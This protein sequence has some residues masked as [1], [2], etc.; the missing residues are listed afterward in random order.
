MRRSLVRYAALAILVLA[1][2]ACGGKKS[3]SS[4]PPAAASSSSAAP[5]T[6]VA[7]AASDTVAKGGEHVV[8]SATVSLLGDKLAL[9]GSGD[10]KS[11]PA[12][13][14]MSL[15]IK[16]SGINAT[17]DEV[18]SGNTAY[19]RTPLL[20]SQLPKGKSWISVNLLKT[21]TAFGVNLNSFTDATP[22]TTLDLLSKATKATKVG[23]NH[24]RATVDLSKIAGKNATAIP[25]DVW[26]NSDGLIEKVS[27]SYTGT[28]IQTVF[29]NYGE[30]VSVK[31][32]SASET[33][34]ISK[35]G[36]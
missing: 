17:V 25:I 18:V 30:K 29:S 24:Y 16:S 15:K 4:T 28:K 11:N 2:A 34:D 3:P 12:L 14:Q 32:P 10:F 23:D 8:V 35:L 5:A 13:G 22:T 7:K 36:G 27:T 33:T 9:A 21:T 31:V 6:A 26:V 1:L 20:T 19:L